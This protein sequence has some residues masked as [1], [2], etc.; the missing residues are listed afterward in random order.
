[1]W[2]FLQT[3]VNGIFSGGV[4][5]LIAVGIT[6]IYGVMRMMNFASGAYLMVGMYITYFGYV[7]TG[8]SNYALIPFTVV[9]SAIVAWLSFV[10]T[11]KP[12][13]NRDKTSSIIVTVGLSFFFQNLVILIFGANP[14]TVPSDIQLSSITLGGFVISLP[15]LIAF[16]SS[17]L[18]MLVLWI[19][20]ERTLFG[21]AMR[22]TSESIEVSEMLGVNTRRVFT[23][24]WV[25][26]ICM[27][28]IAGLLLT[29]VY[30]IQSSTG[31]TFRTTGLMAVVLGGL[32]DI[33]GAFLCGLLIGVIEALVAGYIDTNMGSLGIFIL[34]LVVLHFRP[35]GLF[36]RGERVA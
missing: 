4:Y 6:V 35:A 28:T 13:L 10:L 27:T 5:S 7:L 31:N 34:L 21:K 15:R 17:L 36:G 16:V 32:G 25:L 29:P 3:V 24:A 12:I 19:L 9:V 1:M 14:L 30:A 11:I 8:A 2:Y 33:R 22:A 18:L 20:M 26:G 23:V